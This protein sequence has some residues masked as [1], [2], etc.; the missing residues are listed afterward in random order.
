MYYLF[1]ELSQ[2]YLHVQQFV[3]GQMLRRANMTQNVSSPA[4]VPPDPVEEQYQ[5]QL[6]SWS[7]LLVLQKCHFLRLLY[8]LR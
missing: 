6:A 2:M 7:Q 4:Y 1:D 3:N 5:S 8:K